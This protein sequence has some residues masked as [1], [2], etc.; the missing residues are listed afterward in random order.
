MENKELTGVMFPNEKQNE[1]Q[2]DLKGTVKVGGVDYYI[3]GWKRKSKAG[4]GYLSLA[5]KAKEQAKAQHSAHTA[6]E[7]VNQ[8]SKAVGGKEELQTE[9]YAENDEILPF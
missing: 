1:K 7:T 8:V 4:H 5:L 9:I 6:Q 2:P 3:A